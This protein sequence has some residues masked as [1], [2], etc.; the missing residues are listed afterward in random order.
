ME[1]SDKMEA[2][3]WTCKHCSMAFYSYLQYGSLHMS[4]VRVLATTF[5]FDELIS[6]IS[7]LIIDYFHHHIHTHALPVWLYLI[8]HCE[9]DI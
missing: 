3:I 2:E 7:S 6:M 1:E 9:M 5:E 4:V 8:V